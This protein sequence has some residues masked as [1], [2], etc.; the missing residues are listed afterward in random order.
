MYEARYQLRGT[1]YVIADLYE[2]TADGLGF[3]KLKLV[4]EIY[5]TAQN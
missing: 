2:T 5:E 1:T 4:K 3:S